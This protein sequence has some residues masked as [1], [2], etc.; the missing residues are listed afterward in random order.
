MGRGND[1]DRG[2]GGHQQGSDGDKNDEQRTTA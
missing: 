1:R 2:R